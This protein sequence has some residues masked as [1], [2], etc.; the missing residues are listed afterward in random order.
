MREKEGQDQDLPGPQCPCGDAAWPGFS[1]GGQ[2]ND[3]M[4]GL[5]VGVACSNIDPRSVW[6]AK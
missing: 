4:E 3:G 5:L 2:G 6:E 1:G